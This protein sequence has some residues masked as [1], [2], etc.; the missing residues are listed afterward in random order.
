MKDVNVGVVTRISAT[1]REDGPRQQFQ[2]AGKKK[3][4]FDI[5][6]EKDTLFE[7]KHA[8]GRNLGKLPIIDMPSSFDPSVEAGPSWKHGTLQQL[9]ESFLS[10]E[11]DPDALV[12]HEALLYRPDKVV[13]DSAVNSLQKR[14]TGK[15]MRMNI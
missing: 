3:V 10:L 4:A 13:K 5:A 12:E 9:F 15:E 11:R 6:M 1:T 7:V 8:I 2:F 14:K